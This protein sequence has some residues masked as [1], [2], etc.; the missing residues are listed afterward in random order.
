VELA[1]SSDRV[2]ATHDAEL[3]VDVSHVT[4]VVFTEMNSSEPISTKVSMVGR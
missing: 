3:A 4:L 2:P 1:C